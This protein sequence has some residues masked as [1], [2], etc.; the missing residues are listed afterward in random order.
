MADTGGGLYYLSCSDGV[1]FSTWSQTCDTEHESKIEQYIEEDQQIDMVNIKFLNHNHNSPGIVA[2][3]KTGSHQNSAK[4]SLKIDT[5]RN[6]N[7]LP[8]CVYKILL[9]TSLKNLLA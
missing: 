6:S 9:P 5:G 1:S 2:K 3:L 4:I 8:Y 7:V